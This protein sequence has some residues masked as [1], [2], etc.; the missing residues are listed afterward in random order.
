VG[1][2]HARGRDSAGGFLKPALAVRAVATLATL[3]LWTPTCPAQS[4]PVGTVLSAVVGLPDVLVEDLGTVRAAVAPNGDVYVVDASKG[5][6]HRYHGTSSLQ[7]AS[8]PSSVRD[9][10]DPLSVAANSRSAGVLSGDGLR[11]VVF[12]DSGSVLRPVRRILLKQ[13]ATS[14]CSV[15]GRYYVLGFSTSGIVHEYSEA[16][17]LIRSFGDPLIPGGELLQTGITRGYLA[18]GGDRDRVV[19]IP[20]ILPEMRVYDTTGVLIWR[21]SVPNYRTTIIHEASN[22][23]TVS[24]TRPPGGYSRAESLGVVDSTL[25]ILQTRDHPER[26]V[27]GPLLTRFISIS[28]AQQSGTSEGW[29]RLVAANGATVVVALSGEPTHFGIARLIKPSSS[30]GTAASD[31]P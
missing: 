2:F 19:V 13:A 28:D 8:I 23:Q 17:T 21:R 26:N 31:R 22:G 9:L 1:A 14:M 5:E 16:G 7:S 27:A 15:N 30:N 29:P 3:S 20:A 12:A 18:C 24:M 4:A 11:I 10:T 6:L 25:A